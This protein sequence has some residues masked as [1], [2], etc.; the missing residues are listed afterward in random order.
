VRRPSSGR[1]E[2]RDERRKQVC[3]AILAYHELIQLLGLRNLNH[4]LI[5]D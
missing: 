2:V 3:V 5:R 1:E 4:E